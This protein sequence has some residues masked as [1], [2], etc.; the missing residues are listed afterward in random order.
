MR[1][2]YSMVATIAPGPASSGV[3][4]GTK[5]TLARSTSASEGSPAFPVS[6]S[7][8]T[9]SRSRP[10]AP[11]FQGGQADPQVVQDRPAEQRERHDH[12]EGHDGGLPGQPV[13][14]VPGPAAGQPEEDRHR[15]RRVDDHEQRDE[16]FPEELHDRQPRYRPPALS[17]ADA[18]VWRSACMP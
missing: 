9:S 5:A 7:S 12:A 10:P 15:A 11:P 6:S 14:V 13:P 1:W 17:H 18:A 3:T 16:D 2:T 8:A 4:S